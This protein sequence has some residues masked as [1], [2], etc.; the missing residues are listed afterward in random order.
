MEY[1]QLDICILDDILTIT[2]NI[3]IFLISSIMKLKG[4][5]V[6]VNLVHS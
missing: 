2:Y 5:N 3:M 4:N 1:F 6:T